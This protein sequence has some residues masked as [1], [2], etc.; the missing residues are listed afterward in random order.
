M[1]VIRYEQSGRKEYWLSQIARS[2]WKAGAYLHGRIMT[3][4]DL[5]QPGSGCI[6]AKLYDRIRLQEEAVFYVIINTK[7]K[8]YSEV[9]DYE[10]H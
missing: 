1:E 3:Q 4:Q 2:D 5:K 6:S 8:I 9:L 10:I 7:V